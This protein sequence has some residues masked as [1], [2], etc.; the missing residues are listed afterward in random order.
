M[1]AG[2]KRRRAT[3]RVRYV[4]RIAQPIKLI[5]DLLLSFFISSDGHADLRLRHTVQYVYMSALPVCA[6]Q[7]RMALPAHTNLNP[8]S[9]QLSHAS[10]H[11]RLHAFNGMSPSIRSLVP[12]IFISLSSLHRHLCLYNNVW[13]LLLTARARNAHVHSP[14]TRRTVSNSS[15]SPSPEPGSK[16][17]PSSSSSKRRR[18]R[19]RIRRTKK[20]KAS[21]GTPAANNAREVDDERPPVLCISRNKHWI[22]IS[23]YHVRVSSVSI[24]TSTLARS[25]LLLSTGPVATTT[26]RAA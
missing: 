6:S 15:G 26:T 23:S 22:C 18:R 14:D 21:Q 3:Q 11:G 8:R 10:W 13:R 9:S 5:Y 1:F 17:Q 4:V 19:Q 7:V 20:P 16:T 12:A 25:R 24:E 2:V